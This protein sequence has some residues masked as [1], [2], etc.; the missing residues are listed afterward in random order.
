M[1]VLIINTVRFRLNGMT[2]VIMNY[3]REMNKE[4]MQIDFV[5]INE[6]SS[7]LREEI[8]ATGSKVFLL[9]RKRNPISY[10]YQLNKLLAKEQY[11]IVHVHGNSAIM[12]IETLIA[13]KNK[14]P[15]RIA[16]SHNTTCSHMFFHKIL[17]SLF[18]K[19]YTHALACGKAAGK[20]LFQN[21]PF[22]VLE[23]GIDLRKFKFDENTRREY[24]GKIGVDNKIVLGHVGNFIEQKNHTFLIDFFA[25]I[26]KKNSNY[27]LLLISDGN[28]FDSIKERV[29]K[30]GI[31]DSVIFLG[32]TAEVNKYLQAMDVFVLPSLHEGLPVVLVEAQAVGLPCIVADTVSEESKMTDLLEFIPINGV[33][34]WIKRILE[35][36]LSDRN[37]KCKQ[38]HIDIGKKG[39]D[40]STNADKLK[41]FYS[42]ALL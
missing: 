3:F 24:R 8:F 20:W 11:D 17:Y 16:H 41:K 26:L 29:R 10:I 12:A 4:S 37:I 23:N 14:I 36:N 42:E 21:D 13:K 19:S 18:R 1:K 27:V 25:G 30:L 35:M 28:L 33:D 31:E 15:V 32:K 9:P 22:E 2:S 39:Y 6:L 38:A 34:M 5:V 40:I 7:E